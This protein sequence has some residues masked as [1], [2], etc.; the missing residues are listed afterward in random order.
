LGSHNLTV[1]ATNEAGNAGVSQTV[2]F[3][4]EE[5]EPVSPVVLVAAVSIVVVVAAAG[6]LVYFKKSRHSKMTE[7]IE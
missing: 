6:L 2:C 5:A 7:K 1:Y 3:A 4:I